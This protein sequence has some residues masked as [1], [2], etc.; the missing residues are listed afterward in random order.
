MLQE[1]FELFQKGIKIQPK[2][3]NNIILASTCLHNF[4]IDGHSMEALSSNTN[5]AIDRT[6]DTVF[7]NL[8]GMVVRDCFTEYFSNV[9]NVYWQNKIVNRC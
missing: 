9:G 2:Y 8:E 1:R 5:N 7:N 6:N 4:I 3:I